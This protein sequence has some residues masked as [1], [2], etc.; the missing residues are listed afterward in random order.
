LGRGGIPASS[1]IEDRRG[2]K[3]RERTKWPPGGKGR[4]EH[5]RDTGGGICPGAFSKK[6]Y[7]FRELKVGGLN[8]GGGGGGG[9]KDTEERRDAL[10]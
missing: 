5:R 1:G 4:E 8:W 9:G 3:K 7:T 2:K 6:R 10:S